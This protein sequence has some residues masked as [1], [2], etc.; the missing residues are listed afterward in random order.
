M[1]SAGHELDQLVRQWLSALESSDWMT[2]LLFL[3]AL[4][5]RTLRLLMVLLVVTALPPVGA[6]LSA[7]AE[8]QQQWISKAKK[9]GGARKAPKHRHH[10]H[11]HQLQQAAPLA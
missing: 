7:Q 10:H 1:S 2:L 11:A 5:L 6:E 8:A 4:M 9:K 3:R